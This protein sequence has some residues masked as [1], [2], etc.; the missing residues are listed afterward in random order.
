VIRFLVIRFGWFWTVILASVGGNTPNPDNFPLTGIATALSFQRWWAI[1][2]K[3][4]GEGPFSGHAVFGNDFGQGVVK[5]LNK[6]EFSL[7]QNAH[8]ALVP[9]LVGDWGNGNGGSV[10]I[11]DDREGEINMISINIHN[12]YLYVPYYLITPTIYIYMIY[13]NKI[14][15]S[16]GR[17]EGNWGYS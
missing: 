4:W 17:K 7:S 9:T 14:L 8:I 2:G 1:R 6:G 3:N 16:L 11:E 15:L 5:F 12:G 10:Y 13:I